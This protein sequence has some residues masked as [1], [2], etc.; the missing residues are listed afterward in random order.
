MSPVI[1]N[2]VLAEMRAQARAR[3]AIITG[4]QPPIIGSRPFDPSKVRSAQD[5]VNARR[6]AAFHSRYAG[7]AA[8]LL[9]LWKP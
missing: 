8:A 6:W 9:Q 2:P 5:A 1:R 7:Q 3:G 4:P